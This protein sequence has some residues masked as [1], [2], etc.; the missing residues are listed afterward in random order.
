MT[1]DIKCLLHE[2]L[3]LNSENTSAT[4]SESLLSAF[5]IGQRMNRETDPELKAYCFAF[6]NELGPVPIADVMSLTHALR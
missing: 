2:V 6:D 1:S 4:D 5:L 3:P